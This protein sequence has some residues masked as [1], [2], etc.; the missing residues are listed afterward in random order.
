MIDHIKRICSEFLSSFFVGRYG[1]ISSF[2]PQN[3]TVKVLIQP[4]GTET[5]FVPLTAPWVGPNFGM[6]FGPNGGEQVMLHFIDGSLQAT[7][8]GGMMFN[9]SMQPP[10]I[11]AGQFAVVDSKGS[12]VRLNNDTTI[13]LGATGGI[14]STTPLLKQVG[15]FEVDGNVQVNGNATASGTVTGQTDVVGDGKS[16][17][18]H[19][20]TAPSGGGT[21]SAPN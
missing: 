6:V 8:V 16:F 12:Y 17:K 5:G 1:V 3:Y 10:P 18:G 20:H 13:T 2:N 19:T 4:E 15:N 21:T 14:T 7:I 11:T 9:D